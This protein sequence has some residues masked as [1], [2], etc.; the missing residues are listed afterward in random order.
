MAGQQRLH[1]RQV[2]VE[3]RGP[4]RGVR[5]ADLG[6]HGGR[7]DLLAVERRPVEQADGV[8]LEALAQRDQV[9]QRELG[10]QGAGPAVVA[11]GQRG[12]TTNVPATDW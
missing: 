5:E 11:P 10:L 4:G 1:G 2:V 3:E 7:R 6:L 8:A 9:L 12:D